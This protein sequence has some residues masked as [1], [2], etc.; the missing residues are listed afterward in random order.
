M[1]PRILLT[2]RPAADPAVMRETRYP[3]YVYA[4]D[5]TALRSQ[6]A[7]VTIVPV[8][9]PEDMP[10]ILSAVDGLVVAGGRDVNPER[11]GQI[12]GVHTQEPHDQLDASDIALIRTAREMKIPTIGICRGMQ[13]LNVM[14]GGTLDQD[15]AGKREFHPPVPEDFEDKIAYR[16]MVSLEEDSWLTNVFESSR[17]ETNS[18]HHQCVDEVGENLHVVG[19]A[20]DGTIEAVEHTGDWFAVGVQWH[21]ELLDHPELFFG[22][23]VEYVAEHRASH[24]R[25]SVDRSI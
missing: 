13:V 11:Y 24:D 14:C 1:K 17:I 4:T 10:V 7:I 19:R 16:H 9:D 20:D 8:S 12:R 3:E 22:K 23:F 18:I 2:S 25:R 15:I 6:G 21:P 5:T